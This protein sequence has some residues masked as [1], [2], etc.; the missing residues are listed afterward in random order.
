MQ[1][2]EK[3]E[4]FPYKFLAMPLNDADSKRRAITYTLMFRSVVDKKFMDKYGLEKG[5]GV[6]RAMIFDRPPVLSKVFQELGIDIPGAFRDG[7]GRASRIHKDN[8]APSAEAKA[9][10]AAAAAAPAALGL[11]AAPKTPASGLAAARKALEEGLPYSNIDGGYGKPIN[12]YGLTIEEKQILA[13]EQAE[14]KSTTPPS[15]PPYRP[16]TPSSPPSSPPY[17]PSTPS[18]PPSSPPYR[19]STPSTT[20]PSPPYRPSTPVG[21]TR[22][23]K[24]KAK[25]TRKATKS[26]LPQVAKIFSKVWARLHKK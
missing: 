17:R 26:T 22:K 8:T 14:R 11:A 25:A 15:S 4:T 19:P 3:G 5:F 10:A 13:K 23:R 7:L 6:K 1:I 24:T 2:T 9:F 18:P 12:P 16:S 21:G 20:P